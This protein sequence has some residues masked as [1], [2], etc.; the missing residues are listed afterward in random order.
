MYCVWQ[1]VTTP[2]II[3][4]NP[5]FLTGGGELHACGI[6]D[7]RHYSGWLG[8]GESHGWL[9]R[10]G[11]WNVAQCHFCTANYIFWKILLLFIQST[12][13]TAD[14][15]FNPLNAKLNPICHLLALLGAHPILHIS[16]IRVN[17]LQI[18]WIRWDNVV[19]IVSRILGG[20]S[21]V[22]IP[23]RETFFSSSNRPYW[24]WGL[25]SIFNA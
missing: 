21:A 7:R 6:T 12:L 24:F 18:L 22:R 19:G 2:T 23:A 9:W 3:S 16:R 10:A 8:F 15:L 11:S 13:I 14:Y 25:Q 20:H 1:V 5:V 17:P 4:N